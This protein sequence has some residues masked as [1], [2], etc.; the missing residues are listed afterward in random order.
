MATTPELDPGG[1]VEMRPR[2]RCHFG[3]WIVVTISSCNSFDNPV[4]EA[5]A[6]TTNQQCSDMLS[7]PALCVQDH[8]PHCAA[9]M[10]DD[11][12]PIPVVYKNVSNVDTSDT[13]PAIVGNHL[14]DNAIVIGSLFTVTG[15]Q[16]SANVPRA[17]A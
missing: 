14:Q 17:Y 4:I 9:L 6:C 16:A 15:S 10:S 13:L 11:C 12:K 2:L 5:P 3:I 8:A 1:A 7:E